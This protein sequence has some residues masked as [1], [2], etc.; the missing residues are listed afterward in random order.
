MQTLAPL[1]Q[2]AVPKAA[3][4]VPKAALAARSDKALTPRCRAH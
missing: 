1:A 2:P 3:S 4:A